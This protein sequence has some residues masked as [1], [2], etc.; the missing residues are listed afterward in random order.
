MFIQ[1]VFQINVSAKFCTMKEKKK[2]KDIAN[3]KANFMMEYIIILK[4]RRFAMDDDPFSCCCFCDEANFS[5]EK[6]RRT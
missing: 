1:G 3:F 4:C 6:L 2:A 5:G